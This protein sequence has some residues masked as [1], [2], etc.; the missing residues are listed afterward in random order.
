MAGRC[1]KRQPGGH[2]SHVFR[3]T[4]QLMIP[5]N[6]NEAM[7]MQTS[8]SADPCD[9]NMK[10]DRFHYVSECF[11]QYSCDSGCLFLFSWLSTQIEFPYWFLPQLKNKRIKTKPQSKPDPLLGIVILQ[12]W[13]SLLLFRGGH[14]NQPRCSVS[15]HYRNIIIQATGKPKAV[16]N[17]LRS[18]PK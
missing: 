12:A 5:I 15:T 8:C 17:Q 9:F 2:R 1:A 4:A 10:K 14:G 16:I 13:Q 11:Q 18:S 3:D 6:Y 7:G